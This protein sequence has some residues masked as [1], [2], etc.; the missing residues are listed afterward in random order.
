MKNLTIGMKL[1]LC[2]GLMMLLIV[3]MSVFSFIQFSKNQN[4]LERISNSDF[5]SAN[6]ASAANEAVSQVYRSTNYIIISDDPNLQNRELEQIETKRK[7]IS[8][9]IQ[10][11]DKLETSEQ[12][13]ALVE[14]IKQTVAQATELNSRA[15]KLALDRQQADARRLALG[16]GIIF[17][18]NCEKAFNELRRY[19]AE[20]VDFRYK[21][22]FNSNTNARYGVVACL[23][24]IAIAVACLVL[25]TLGITRPIRRMRNT[26]QDM[27][28]GEGDLTR[29]LDETSHDELGE[30]CRMFNIFLGRLQGILFQLNES[31]RH[32]TAE[33]GQLLSVADQFS[34]GTDKV[35]SEIGTVAAACEEMAATSGDIAHNCQLAADSTSKVEASASES[36]YIVMESVN[37]MNS[38]NEQVIESASA[39]RELGHRSEEIG[40]IVGT[41]EDIADQTNLL[42]LNAA[43]EAARAGEQGR[44]FAV[45]ADEVRAL[46]ERTTRATREISEMIKTIQ[47]ETNKA[48]ALMDDGVAKVDQGV[49]ESAK[50]SEALVEV[51]SMV[52]EITSQVGQI[53][54][55]AEQQTATTNEITRNIQLVNRVVM[56]SSHGA[57]E[58]AEAAASLSRRAMELQRLVGQFKLA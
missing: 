15:I 53:A 24:A 39:I 29:R 30:A 26:L 57:S 44:G 52:S 13:R 32:F 46:A 5:A 4:S 42:A 55:A 41:I 3:V 17:A 56:E 45:V 1:G 50:S 33:S 54:I 23:V 47:N 49:S 22:A 25:V 9:K 11:L 12:G 10:I 14:R 35:A 7:L 37:I 58:T 20:S 36:A 27:A 2:F 8:E 21:E 28:Q 19:Q 38:I 16:D 31:A 51:L 34:N 18:D 48:V 6:A 40:E 43:I